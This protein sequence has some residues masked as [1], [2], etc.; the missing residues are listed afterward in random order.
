MLPPRRPRYYYGWTIMVVSFITGGFTAGLAIWAPSVLVLPMREA[1]G[2]SLT[3][4]FWA[5]SIRAMV[6]AFIAPITGPWLDKRG[7]ARVL[8]SVGVVLMGISL[9]GSGLIGKIGVLDAIDV[10]YQF[11]FFF[12]VI[13]AAAFTG[14]GFIIANAV[15]PK[16]FIRKR[17]RAMGIASMGTG[18]G[19]MAFPALALLFIN[20][21]GWREAWVA[22][23]IICIVVQLPFMLLVRTRPE[24][25]GL[26]P[27]GAAALDEPTAD[28]GV[29]RPVEHSVTRHQALRMPVFWVVV[30]AIMLASTGFQG[31]QPNWVPYIQEIG[32]SDSLAVT[33][34]AVYGL[35]SGATRG[36]WGLLA[37]RFAIRNLLM[38]QM[39]LTA[40]SIVI[41][42]YAVNPTMVMAY[43]VIAGMTMGGFFILQPLL[44]ASY[45]GRGHLG[46]VSTAIMPFNTMAGAVAPLLV[47]SLHDARGDY[48]LAFSLT[49]V[50]WLAAAAV[51]FA[52][53]PPAPVG[54]AQDAAAR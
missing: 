54:L 32:F 18:L 35:F 12:G 3:D 10:R 39:T 17:G 23:G 7:G 38:V 26:L 11:Y 20:S 6:A 25:M 4:F 42:I 48:T 13:G 9:M 46:S 50:V 15:L 28:E 22:L 51:V 1:L 45:F 44:V 16:W 19:P 36:V 8:G 30:A 5:F 53:R 29:R 24:D 37:E 2:W 31:F 27:D 34:V 33:G 52:S 41:L 21:M 47:S 14:S 49:I 40:A 43:M